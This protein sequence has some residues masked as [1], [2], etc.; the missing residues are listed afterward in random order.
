MSEQ[1]T[2]TIGSGTGHAGNQT[3]ALAFFVLLAASVTAFSF[4][5]NE[6]GV[7]AVILLLALFAVAGICTSFAFAAGLLRFSGRASR[8]DLTKLICDGNA[9]GQLVIGAGAKSFT[10]TKPI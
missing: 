4:L 2:S 5:P 10:R 8:N 3:L 6:G 7:T 9:E 1:T